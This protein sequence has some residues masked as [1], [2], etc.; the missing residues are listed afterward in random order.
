MDPTDREVRQRRHNDRR[1]KLDIARFQLCIY[2]DEYD[3]DRRPTYEER[4]LPADWCE[5]HGFSRTLCTNYI[6]REPW[7]TE[8][9]TWGY[10]SGAH[11]FRVLSDLDRNQELGS[12]YLWNNY[13]RRRPPPIMEQLVP[14]DKLPK[15][16]WG[17]FLEYYEAHQHSEDERTDDGL[18][19]E[20]AAADACPDGQA[21][22]AGGDTVGGRALRYLDQ[23]KELKQ[24]NPMSQRRSEYMR[25]N[26]SYA[27]ASGPWAR[28]AF[29]T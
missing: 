24:V 15:W 29:K 28:L 27:H 4:A 20:Q 19:P 5:R 16:T 12:R 2:L 14:D 10:S 9:N 23:K 25:Q 26:D 13:S 11:Y 7:I 18:A 17:Q 1:I 3:R 8:T 21:E 6:D 22:P